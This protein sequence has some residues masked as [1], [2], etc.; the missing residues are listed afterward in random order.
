MAIEQI[1]PKKIFFIKHSNLSRRIDPLFYAWGLDKFLKNHPIVALGDVCKKFR[2][3]FGAGKTDQTD[4]TDGILHLRPTN[5][6]E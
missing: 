4:A 3:G 2:S 5:L 6:D 1:V